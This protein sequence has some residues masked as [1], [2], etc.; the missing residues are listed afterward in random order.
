[1]HHNT[2]WKKFR[3]WLLSPLGQSLITEQSEKINEF[4][5]MVFGFHIVFLGEPPLLKGLQESPILHRVWIH[6]AAEPLK[7]CDAVI[8]RQDKLPIMQDEIDLVYLAHCLEF[9][10]NPH[11]VLR[12][13]YAAL[14]PGGHLI[15]SGFNAWSSWGLWRY[16]VHYIKPVPWDANFISLKRL[17]DWLALLGFDVVQ[18]K[19]CFFRPPIERGTWLEKMRWIEKVGNFLFSPLGASYVILARKRALTLTPLRVEW[20][21]RRRMVP[22]GFAEPVRRGLR[23]GQI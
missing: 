16:L 8:A 6:P 3:E 13:A 19:S 7:E 15:I 20:K 22:A 11:E 12:E 10:L 14:K 23:R 1:V 4:I 9:N 2:Q 17:K 21:R 18:I 5:Q